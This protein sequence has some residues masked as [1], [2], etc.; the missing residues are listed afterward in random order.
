MAA[1]SRT[2]PRLAALFA[3]GCL[4]FN[5]PLVAVFDRPLT[6]ADYRRRTGPV[7]Q[8]IWGRH[9][10][11]AGVEVFA[12]KMN[13]KLIVTGHQ[14]QD[15]GYFVNGKRHLIIASEHNQGVFLPLSLS[16]GYDMEKLVGSLRKFVSINI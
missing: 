3:L 2:G 10:S 15:T 12:E 11:P 7:Y 8:L 5:Y 4:L 16:E 1:T 14:P 13:A 6:C 9:V